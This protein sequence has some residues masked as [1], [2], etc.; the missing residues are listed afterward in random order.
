MIDMVGT[1]GRDEPLLQVSGL[2]VALRDQ[3]V[4]RDVV[5]GVD[6]A[7]QPG[8]VLTILGE[9]GSGK[10]VTLRTIMSLFPPGAARVSGCIRFNGEELGKV[11]R[12]RLQQI[13]GGEIGFVF[14][15]PM[16]ALDPVFC[17]GDQIAE[18]LMQHRGMSHREGLARA[19]A[20]FDLVQI[21]SAARR[22]NALPFELSGGLRQRVM[23]A[24]AIACE[25]K[26]LLA[27]EPTTALDATVQIQILALLRDVQRQFGMSIL[28]V[29]HDLAVAGSISDEIAVMYRGEVV[30]YGPAQQILSAPE[31]AYTAKLVSSQVYG[32]Y[33]THRLG[34]EDSLPAPNAC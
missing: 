32:N 4:W 16:T 27:D 24:M 11:S 23:I 1:S 31:H 30:E 25:P 13:R 5:K 9:S 6:L 2:T 21:P 20:L 7:V 8:G 14:Q 26:L 34:V 15:E 3:R 17:V 29:T 28:F 12:T 19:R 18:I 10:S 22:L 33:R